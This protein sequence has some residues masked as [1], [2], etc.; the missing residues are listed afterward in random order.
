MT[1]VGR[2]KRVDAQSEAVRIRAEQAAQRRHP[3]ATRINANPAHSV[4]CIV[5]VFFTNG[6]ATLYRF[7]PEAA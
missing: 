3:D 1:P 7:H 6:P 4:G 5:E 2:H